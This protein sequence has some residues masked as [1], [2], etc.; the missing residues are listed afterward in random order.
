MRPARPSTR[1]G[2]PSREATV[3]RIGGARRMPST[4]SS[5]STSTAKPSPSRTTR[6]QSTARA[7][8]AAAARL[9]WPHGSPGGSPASERSR[10]RGTIER[11]GHCSSAV[12]RSVPT[13]WRP[14]SP[15]ASSRSATA[16]AGWL[17]QPSRTW[18]T[19]TPTSAPAQAIDARMAS[20]TVRSRRA[21]RSRRSPSSSAARLAAS[22]GLCPGSARGGPLDEGGQLPG[23]LR[24]VGY[25]GGFVLGGGDCPDTMVRKSAPTA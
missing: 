21:T 11:R 7:P 6:P 18:A 12:A 15:E 8:A 24:P 14:A 16:T 4:G 3:S 23:E 1:E 13:P 17:L 25:W 5:G 20:R 19:P 22:A 9:A 10:P 2:T